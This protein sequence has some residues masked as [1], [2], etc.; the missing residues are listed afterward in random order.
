MNP[1]VTHSSLGAKNLLFCSQQGKIISREELE[2][3][4]A[5]ERKPELEVIDNI[6]VAI[7][8]SNLLI[9]FIN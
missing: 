6:E 8:L 3:I 2:E 5:K 1:K 7:Q 9:I 4:L